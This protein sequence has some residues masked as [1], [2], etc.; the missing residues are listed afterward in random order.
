M[1]HLKF[2]PFLIAA[3][4][5]MPRAHAAEAVPVAEPSGLSVLL[6]LLGLLALSLGGGARATTIKPEQH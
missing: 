3:A 2:L 6:V 1:K 4:S 5:Y